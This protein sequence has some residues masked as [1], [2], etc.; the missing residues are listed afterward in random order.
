MPS[1][2]TF[3]TSMRKPERRP[4][5]R[6]RHSFSLPLSRLQLPAQSACAVYRVVR[7]LLGCASQERI[8][9]DRPRVRR[10]CS[11][12]PSQQ[13]HPRQTRFAT[14]VYCASSS[15]RLRRRGRR[16]GTARPLPEVRIPVTLTERV[17]VSTTPA[18]HSPQTTYLSK[19]DR[20]EN[21]A[22]VA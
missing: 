21:Q 7:R 19:C 22:V 8:N 14:I 4:R 5:F 17:L 6:N 3:A 12:H 9:S 2:A 18:T 10:P 16:V 11:G 20:T 1:I 15:G 13:L